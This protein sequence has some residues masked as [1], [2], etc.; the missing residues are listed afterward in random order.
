MKASVLMF[1]KLGA[2]QLT[3]WVSWKN[4]QRTYNIEIALQSNQ[5]DWCA[6]LQAAW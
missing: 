4:E 3:P 5:V 1:V 2:H 6:S